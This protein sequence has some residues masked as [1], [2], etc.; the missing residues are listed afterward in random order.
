[1]TDNPSATGP[2]IGDNA[3]DFSL[4]ADGGD[5]LRLADFKGRKLVLYFYP[6]DNTPGC[7]TE[8][9]DFSRL[10]AEFDAADTV[11]LGVSKDSVKKHDNFI[12]KQDLK[13]R[14]LSDEKGD[15]C[16]R[17]GVWQEKQMY[18]RSYMGINRSSFLI[19]REGKI[20]HLWP[21]VKV[22]GHADEVLAACQSL[23]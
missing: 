7:T 23:A 22:K 6:K 3:P 12:A 20:A 2:A 9:K 4:P 10:K 14:L 1:M 11:V 19:D 8:A 21:K 16:E 17:Y 15:L 13:I 18:G 5:T